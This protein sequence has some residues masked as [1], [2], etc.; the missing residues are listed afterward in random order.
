MTT[1]AEELQLIELT[2]GQTLQVPA[3]QECLALLSQAQQA[4]IVVNGLYAL[5]APLSPRKLG[6][7]VRDGADIWLLYD[8]SREGAL[9]QALRC[10]LYAL[11]QAEARVWQFATIDED[12]DQVRRLWTRA[13]ELALQWGL[14]YLFPADFLPARL[15][16]AET[17][18]EQ[19]W[20]AGHLAG[21]LTPFIARAA[22]DALCDIREREGWSLAFFGEALAGLSR[23]ERANRLVLD[24]NR[25]LLGRNWRLPYRPEKAF[26]ESALPPT[27][28]SDRLL[29]SALTSCAEYPTVLEQLNWH[30]SGETALRFSQV[31]DEQ[32]L[33]AALGVLNTL[34]LEEAPGSK[35]AQWYCYGGAVRRAVP[36]LYRLALNYGESSEPG[37]S[38]ALLSREVWILFPS[39][40]VRHLDFEAA[41]QRYIT[42]WLA[43]QGVVVEGPLD[44]LTMLWSWLK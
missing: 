32:D 28:R 23:D 31:E 1:V 26:G 22:Y 20:H 3:P 33:Y 15:E 9:A 38:V 39:R 42:S 25:C 24:F 40:H 37:A 5:R 2:S 13:A 16:E 36:P 12:W 6:G 35:L 7:F 10:E 8:E 27:P 41:L 43:W 29:R 34:L 14:E 19:H 4:D 21:C 17:L 30:R 18:R 11:A 44:G